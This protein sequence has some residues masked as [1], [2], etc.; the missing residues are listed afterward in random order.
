[1]MVR[2]F[3][4]QFVKADDNYLA[5]DIK[6]PSWVYFTKKQWWNHLTMYILEQISS[7]LKKLGLYQAIRATCNE[8]KVSAP[9]FYI[10]FELYFPSSKMF[11]TLVGELGLALHVMWEVSK[12]PMGF[13]LY[14]E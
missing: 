3:L 7:E 4:S 10:H 2:T 9:N 12:L 5:M 6:M 8:I 13:L 1:M 11:F 14:E